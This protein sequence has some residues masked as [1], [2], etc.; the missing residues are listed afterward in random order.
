MNSWTN[1]DEKPNQR[2]RSTNQR[3]RLGNQRRR[4]GNQRRGFVF[5]TL[6]FLFYIETKGT[7]HPLK[8]I[9][10]LYP[11]GFKNQ[12][13]AR[14]ARDFG[15]LPHYFN[16]NQSVNRLLQEWQENLVCI[17]FSIKFHFILSINYF[18]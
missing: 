4:L 13:V 8:K 5:K 18:A 3:R 11:K 15:P 10:I 1:Q 16:E 7:F 14:V 9:I 6:L 12:V 17:E 2:R